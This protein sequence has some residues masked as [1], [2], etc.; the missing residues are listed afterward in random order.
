MG[1]KLGPKKADF[2]IKQTNICRLSGDII[3]E[4]GPSNDTEIFFKNKSGTVLLPSLQKP[5]VYQ[6]YVVLLWCSV[7]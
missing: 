4:I 3:I 1:P 7:V 2:A 5:Q 6:Q